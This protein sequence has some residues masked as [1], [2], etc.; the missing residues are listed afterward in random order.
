[1]GR[2]GLRRLGSRRLNVEWAN[3]GGPDDSDQAETEPTVQ[4]PRGSAR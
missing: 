2:S 1:M 4:D 3:P